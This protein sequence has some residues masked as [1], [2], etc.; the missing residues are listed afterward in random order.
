MATL[1][2]KSSR[3]T[4]RESELRTRGRRMVGAAIVASILGVRVDKVYELV[5]SGV[6]LPDG[7]NIRLRASNLGTTHRATWKFRLRDVDTFI[8]ATQ[9]CDVSPPQRLPSRLD[10]RRRFVVRRPAG[11]V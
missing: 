9:A 7:R 10:V 8:D 11:S 1:T 4:V 2:H 5:G 3:S 6:T